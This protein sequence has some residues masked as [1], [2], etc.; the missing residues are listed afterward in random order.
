MRVPNHCTLK[1]SMQSVINYIFIVLLI[2]NGHLL[3]GFVLVVI[4]RV[5]DYVVEDGGADYSAQYKSL[6]KLVKSLQTEILSKLGGETSKPT[7]SNPSR[8]FL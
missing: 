2:Y 6:E 5:A 7:S 1:L 4:F 8:Y 3:M